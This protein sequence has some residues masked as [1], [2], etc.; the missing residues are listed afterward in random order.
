MSFFVLSCNI[1]SQLC[2]SAFLKITC[3]LIFL[4]HSQYLNLYWYTNRYFHLALLSYHRNKNFCQI[5]VKKIFKKKS[6]FFKKLRYL[7]FY[8]I[9]RNFLLF[10]LYFFEFSSNISSSF[11]NLDKFSLLDLV[12]QLY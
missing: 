5:Y 1:M 6:C 3:T 9:S 2:F 12:F 10:L 11:S 7:I 8:F 4:F